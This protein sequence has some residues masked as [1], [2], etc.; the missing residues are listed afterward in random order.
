MGMNELTEEIEKSLQEL[1]TVEADDI[2]TSPECAH[3]GK[4]MPYEDYNDKSPQDDY[5]SHVIPGE[6]E[7][8]APMILLYCDVSCFMKEIQMFE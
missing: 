1:D 8:A 2:D 5:I 7:H 6:N 3:C 4:E